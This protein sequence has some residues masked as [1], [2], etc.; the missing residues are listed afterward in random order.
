ML[1]K[2]SLQV[3]GRAAVAGLAYYWLGLGVGT[4][5]Q[6]AL[7]VGVALV[8]LIALAWLDAAG[9]GNG[10]NWPWALPAVAILGAV[11]YKSWAIFAIIIAWLVVLLPTAAAGSFRLLTSLRYIGT[12]I[13]IL[14]LSV[15][16][17][18]ALLLWTPLPQSM[19]FQLFSFAGRVVLAACFLFGG[20][21][22]LLHYIGKTTRG[23]P[24]KLAIEVPQPE[25]PAS[26]TPA[27]SPS[28]GA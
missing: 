25:G 7:N 23:N 20:W 17:A 18:I 12:G 28:P 19:Y 24:L 5:T 14:T 13:A 4:A 15:V 21:G 11:A 3:V 26:N 6:V 1:R 22:F 10:K 2:L 27:P 16:P 8:I 9:L